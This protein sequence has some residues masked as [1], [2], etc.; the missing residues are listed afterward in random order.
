MTDRHPIGLSPRLDGATTEQRTLY[1]AIE[2]GPRGSVPRPFL[3]MLDAPGLANSIQAVGLSIRFDGCLGGGRRELAI[4]ATAGALSCAY[5]WQYHEP[6]ARAAGVAAD[7]IAATRAGYDGLPA[8][9]HDSA[10]VRLCR[11]LVVARRADEALVDALVGALG[12]RA[13][14]ELVA[15]AGYYSLLASFIA[16]GKHEPIDSLGAALI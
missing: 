1:K 7:S 5:E 9:E 11:Q 15:I 16:V 10:I 8:D 14:T 2:G 4:L 6:I 12:R 13:V 3:A